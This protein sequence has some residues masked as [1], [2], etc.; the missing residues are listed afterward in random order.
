MNGYLP[1][2]DSSTAQLFRAS[3]LSL[4]PSTTDF[5]L[6][7]VIPISIY[8]DGALLPGMAENL[9]GEIKRI[10]TED[11]YPPFGQWGPF[12]GSSFI[13]LFGRGEKPESGPSV[14]KR[15]KDL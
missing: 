13:T 14:Q 12:Y 10:M 7:R 9:T 15:L 11:G 2:I 8:V 5:A 6:R 4:D 1:T 3:H